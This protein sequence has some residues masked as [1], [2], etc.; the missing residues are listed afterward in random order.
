MT[1]TPWLGRAALALA[2]LTLL[3]LPAQAQTP[4]ALKVIFCGTSGPLPVVGRAKPCTAIQAGGS[5]YLVDIGPEATENFQL[6]RLPLATAKAVFITHLHS[7][8]IGDLGE[9]NMQT[10]VAG[11]PGPLSLRL[12]EAWVLAAKFGGIG[13]RTEGRPGAGPLWAPGSA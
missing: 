11:R 10:W 1:P 6:W 8:H 4:D 9:F 7:D 3:A 2:T 5:L 13:R 12:S